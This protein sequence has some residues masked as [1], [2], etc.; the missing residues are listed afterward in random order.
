M[1]TGKTEEG[2]KELGK[3]PHHLT[4]NC[5]RFHFLLRIGKKQLAFL[6]YTIRKAEEGNLTLRH[7]T[8]VK[9]DIRNE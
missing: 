4:K 8:E 5:V 3:S 1:D 2:D 9:R 7:L 6:V